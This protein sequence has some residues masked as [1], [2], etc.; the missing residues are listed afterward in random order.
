MGSNTVSI[1][2]L[3]N[4][5]V[6]ATIAVGLQPTAVTLN[7]NQTYAYVADYGDGTLYE[8]NLSNNSVSRTATVGTAAQ[9]VAMDPGGSAVWVGGSGYLKKV[10][11]TSFSVVNTVSVNGTVTSVAASNQQNALVY[12]LVSNPCCSGGSTYSSN[13]LQLGNLTG[14]GTYAYSSAIAYSESTTGQTLPNPSVSSQGC[15]VSAQWGN[16]MGACAT[17]TGFVIYDVVSN[18][19]VMSGTTPTPLRGIGSDPNN[20]VVLLTMPDSNLYLTVPLPPH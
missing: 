13:E 3:V 5:V 17:A 10:D 6:M 7:S 1:V 11:L 15:A 2:D 20:S 14:S 9:S 4:N 12:S 18:T 16:G 8:I 19:Q